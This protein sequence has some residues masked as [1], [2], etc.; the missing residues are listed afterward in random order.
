MSQFGGSVPIEYFTLEIRRE[1]P[2]SAISVG[3]Q[4]RE[5]SST[6]PAS[7]I[8]MPVSL[9]VAVTARSTLRLCGR[10]NGSSARD[11]S[12]SWMNE[13]RT[14]SGTRLSSDRRRSYPP[15]A[16]FPQRLPVTLRKTSSGSAFK[17]VVRTLPPAPRVSMYLAAVSS[18]GA[19]SMMTPS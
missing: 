10:R 18:S 17:V 2:P 1:S 14:G 13:L 11:W 12:I 16:L 3:G 4:F 6:L 19:S 9:R 15:A 8:A 7:T 5:P